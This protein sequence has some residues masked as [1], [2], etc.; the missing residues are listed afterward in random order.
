MSTVAP[1]APT[2]VEVDGL[3]VGVL[4][5]DGRGGMQAVT[6]HAGQLLGLTDDDLAAGTRPAGWWLADDRGAPLPDLPALAGQVLRADTAATV[7]VM[8]GGR[9]L[10][11]ELYPVVLHGRRHALA[12]LRPVH[13]DVVRDKGLF[14]PVTG[15]P[16]RVLLFDRLDQALRRARVRATLVTLVLA[17]LAAP[18][19]RMLGQ[20]SDALVGGLAS[21][22]T[23][24]RYAGATFAV[25]AD[26]LSGGGLPV[27]RRVVALSPHPV[28]VGWVTSDG[29]HTVHDVVA[30][31]EAELKQ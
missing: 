7:A 3:S 11:L 13:T 30:K 21:D 15:L 28:R 9:R 2:R 27:A 17:E 5:C 22:Q 25:V 10:W 23:V 4:L 29:T 1:V 26:H 14:D 12:V 6:A 20:L 8:V 16:N 24:A 18:D 19:D 31:A